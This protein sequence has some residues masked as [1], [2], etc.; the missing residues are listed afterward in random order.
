MKNMIAAAEKLQQPQW[1]QL[2]RG[3]AIL[4]LSI[5]AII[6]PQLYMQIMAL[7][8]QSLLLLAS[9]IIG[10]IMTIA[11]I[12]TY[13]QPCLRA[14]YQIMVQ[15][16]KKYGDDIILD[17]ILKEI[18]S[19]DGWISTMLGSCVGTT[20]LYYLPIP[21]RFRK[22][23]M[24]NVIYQTLGEEEFEQQVQLMEKVIFQPGG[25][26]QLL[27]L[28]VGS[29]Y[30]GILNGASYNNTSD[31]NRDGHNS[32][33]NIQRSVIS[34][35]RDDVVDTD[36]ELTLDGESESDS[37]LGG[38]VEV[39]SSIQAS[40]PISQNRAASHSSSLNDHNHDTTSSATTTNEQLQ[41][42]DSAEKIAM[43]VVREICNSLVSKIH[44]D[45]NSHIEKI[46]ALAG[47]ALFFQ[48][49][50]SRVARRTLYKFG[51]GSTAL[52]LGCIA[53][54]TFGSM[55]CKRKFLEWV[56]ESSKDEGINNKNNSTSSSGKSR[57]NKNS[58]DNAGSESVISLRKIVEF[59][60]GRFNPDVTIKKRVQVA[61][62]MMLLAFF[63]KSKMIREGKRK[64]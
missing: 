61:F 35:G 18:L 31:D 42:V 22:R 14:R 12:N 57:R 63:R 48:M 21:K 54:G 32:N 53:A 16:I 45:S 28:S 9:S 33:Y 25:I 24:R 39:N 52:G 11:D 2:M 41:N 40:S 38:E 26:W 47:I 36:L 43:D 23:I 3:P 44:V 15:T 59:V 62:A 56:E 1:I 27:S 8:T 4:S 29:T 30:G 51:Q 46:G 64:Y 55:L 60:A 17:D 19:V 34:D 37:F 49:R 50:H 6:L 10:L 13:I 7:S 20:I 58:K 5:A